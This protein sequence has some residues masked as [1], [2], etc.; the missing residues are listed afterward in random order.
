MIDRY[1]GLW[2]KWQLYKKLLIGFFVLNVFCVVSGFVLSFNYWGF[3]QSLREQHQVE[4][5]KLS[6]SADLE[7]Q[8]AEL[9]NDVVISSDRA[10]IFKEATEWQKLQNHLV[11]SGLGEKFLI[12][13]KAVADRKTALAFLR[14]IKQSLAGE[15]K[16]AFDKLSNM[17][18][19]YSDTTWELVSIGILTLLFGLIIPG[20]IIWQLTRLLKRTTDELRQ[21]AREIAREWIAQNEK[22]GGEG[23]KNIEFWVEIALLGAQIAGRS[24]GHPV[25]QMTGELALLIRQE[26][27]KSRSKPAA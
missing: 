7:R 22:F 10:S 9:E 1:N 17:V 5:T 3:K 19:S 25:A 6:A 16:A 20:F 2:R 14:D 26:L 13:P 23:F 15:R 12:E 11:A 8:I 24:A 18:E 27:E 4:L 21:S